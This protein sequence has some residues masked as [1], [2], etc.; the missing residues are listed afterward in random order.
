MMVRIVFKILYRESTSKR[1][2]KKIR[3]KNRLSKM[4]SIKSIKRTQTENKRVIPIVV[5]HHLLLHLL[6]PFREL[7]HK[8][9][10]HQKRIAK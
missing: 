6:I 4:L 5:H 9:N 7:Y 10:P 2:L 1:K 3:R 8:K